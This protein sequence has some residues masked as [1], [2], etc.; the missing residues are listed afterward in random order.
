MTKL[1]KLYARIVRNP[2][3][4]E[5]AEIDKIL[6]RYGF[7]RRQPGRGSSH[8]T[9]YHPTI[10]DILTIPKDKP[11]KAVYIKE[12]IIAIEKLKEEEQL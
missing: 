9:Y 6:K 11:V 1:D 7:K 3:N 4:V 12:A 8:Y 5:F 10:P 2:K